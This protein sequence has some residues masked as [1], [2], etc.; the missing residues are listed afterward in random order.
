MPLTPL[1]HPGSTWFVMLVST[2]KFN[3]SNVTSF[4][5]VRDE[6]D[7]KPE[8]ESKPEKMADEDENEGDGE[9]Q[10]KIAEGDEGEEEEAPKETEEDKEKRIQAEKKAKEAAIKQ[11]VLRE[12]K[13]QRNLLYRA[14]WSIQ[15]KFADP[16]LLSHADKWLKFQ[17]STELI[18]KTFET[19]QLSR[20]VLLPSDVLHTHRQLLIHCWLLLQAVANVS[21]NSSFFPKYLTG[22]QLL[23]LQMRDPTFRRHLLIQ[24]LILMQYLQ[25]ACPRLCLVAVASFM[26]PSL[27]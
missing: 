18:L 16:N 11:R 13:N 26:F 17:A 12:S 4:E 3:T 25:G 21:A 23:G 5:D 1:S 10:E 9:D 22:N 7:P 19:Q 8:S 27:D 14:V 2:G 6:P 20:Q 24:F 15:D